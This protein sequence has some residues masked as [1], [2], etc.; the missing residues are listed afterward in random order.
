MTSLRRCQNNSFH[1]KSRNS[2]PSPGT[3]LALG[4]DELVPLRAGE[5][6]AWRLHQE[7]VAK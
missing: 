3:P 7:A 2:A 6:L 4:E 5:R 1:L